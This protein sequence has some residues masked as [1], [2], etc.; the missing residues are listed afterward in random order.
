MKIKRLFAAILSAMMIISCFSFTANAQDASEGETGGTDS[1]QKVIISFDS[2][3]AASHTE[4]I[5]GKSVRISDTVSTV[6]VA[7]GEN[8]PF[9]TTNPT[10]VYN[11][12]KGWSET[13][14]GEAIADTSAIKATEA[15]TYYAVWEYTH[16]G[17]VLA[18][19]N[20]KKEYKNASSI[21]AAENCNSDGKFYDAIDDKIFKN[22]KVRT[23]GN[24]GS[25][26]M[27]NGI[28]Y[29]LG[30]TELHMVA[31]VRTNMTGYKPT[32]GVYNSYKTD[33]LSYSVSG[34]ITASEI[35]QDTD[36]DKWV[37]VYLSKTGLTDFGRGT[38]IDFDVTGNH[39]ANGVGTDYYDVVG[40]A[41][42]NTLEEAEA[43]DFDTV[44]SS[45]YQVYFNANYDNAENVTTY[46]EV[47]E[48]RYDENNNLL[49]FEGWT[50]D[51]SLAGMTVT[52]EEAASL[53][54][55]GVILSEEDLRYTAIPTADVTY[56]AVWGDTVEQE[57]AVYISADGSDENGG[58]HS[59][60][61]V[62]T[63]SKAYSLI[64]AEGSTIDTIC[65][66]GVVTDAAAKELGITGKTLTFKGYDE[67]AYLYMNA[68]DRIKICGDIS[69]ENITIESNFSTEVHF[70]TINAK[71]ITI[72]E[73]VE[74]K[75]LNSSGTSIT[76]STLVGDDYGSSQNVNYEVVVNGSDYTGT[77]IPG[78][79]YGGGTKTGNIKAVI[80]GGTISELRLTKGS[81]GSGSVDNK[82]NG[83]VEYEINGGTV[84][85]LHFGHGGN[86]NGLGYAVV[87]GGTVDMI[88]TKSVNHSWAS[89]VAN[90]IPL[91]DL[92]GVMVFEI[93]GGTVKRFATQSDG[94]DQ[95]KK[96]ISNQ[97]ALGNTVT[98]YPDTWGNI[99]RIVIFND[100][101]EA[102]KVEDTAA[103]VL[104]VT[105][106]KIK[107]VATTPTADNSYASELEGFTYTL[108][109][110]KYKIAEI[111]GTEYP[112][113][114]FTD[115]YIPVT[116]F[117]VGKVNTVKFVREEPAHIKEYRRNGYA[118][119]YVSATGAGTKD[120]SNPEN[121]LQ[122]STSFA[123]KSDA[124]LVYALIDNTYSTG[125]I[126]WAIQ[127]G[128]DIVIT[129]GDGTPFYTGGHINFTNNRNGKITF[130]NIQ[131]VYGGTYAAA[132]KHIATGIVDGE[133][134][135]TSRGS[136]MKFTETFVPVP[137]TYNGTTRTARMFI[138]P[139][140]D[141]NTNVTRTDNIKFEVY[142]GTNYQIRGGG[143]GG[144]QIAAGIDFVIGGN[145]KADGGFIASAQ[146]GGAS[147]SSIKKATFEG[148]INA[149]TA[150]AVEGATG[151]YLY[152]GS[153]YS[154]KGAASGDYYKFN[155][156]TGKPEVSQGYN[157]EGR[158]FGGTVNALIKDNANV[159]TVT[160]ALKGRIKGDFNITVTDNATVGTI[161]NTASADLSLDTI[162]PATGALNGKLT[163]PG[164]AV[165]GDIFIKIDG[166]KV[167]TI[168]GTTAGKTRNVLINLNKT[169]LPAMSGVTRA[170][171]Y[172]GDGEVS[173]NEDFTTAKLTFGENAT[174]VRITNGD[175]VKSYAVSGDEVILLEEV[176]FNAIALSEGTTTFE[177]FSEGEAI[178]QPETVTLSFYAN[179]PDADGNV[180]NT[181]AWVTKTVAWGATDDVLPVWS[182]VGR[183]SID[184][185]DTF[186][187]PDRDGYR[188]LGWATTPD[189]TSPD[190]DP[191]TFTVN[192]KEVIDGK[193]YAV[194]EQADMIAADEV[195]ITLVSDKANSPIPED[196]TG[197][198]IAFAD[199]KYSGEL[200]TVYNADGTAYTTINS[201]EA[202]PGL[203]KNTADLTGTTTTSS[204]FGASGNTNTVL[205]P[206]GTVSAWF[207]W[208][209]G[210]Y[211]GVETPCTGLVNVAYVINASPSA[212]T[213]RGFYLE[214]GDVNGTLNLTQVKDG[215]A[216]FVV[217]FTTTLEE[218]DIIKYAGPYDFNNETIKAAQLLGIYVWPVDTVYL[219][220]N[221]SD[222][223]DGYTP[224][225]AVKTLAKVNT[226]LAEN[227]NADTIVVVGTYSKK[228]ESGAATDNFAKNSC[229]NITI[230]GYDDN[231]VF[232]M[233]Y[234]SSDSH[235]RFSANVTFENIKITG[236]E[237]DGGIMS[238]GYELT[239]GEGVTVNGSQNVGFVHYT[240]PYKDG[241]I[242]NLHSGT[243]N[244]VDI[245]V[246]SGATYKGTAT[247]NVGE[248]VTTKITNG[249][250]HQGEQSVYGISNVNI[251]GGNVTSITLSATAD[252]AVT[253][254]SG[255]RYFT[256]NGGTV[257]DIT[258]TGS[259]VS[260]KY[261]PTGGTETFK[262]AS[263]R[264]GVTVFEINGG[265]V[266]TIKLGTNK[267]TGEV[268]PDNATRVVIFNNG[269]TANVT[270]TGAVV[271]NVQN[272][273]LSAVTNAYDAEGNPTYTYSSLNAE[274]GK[275]LELTGFSYTTDAANEYIYI[276]GTNYL[277]SDFANAGEEA[278]LSEEITVLIPA[279]LF[280][281]GENTA[282]FSEDPLYTVTW[283][284]GD[285]IVK[286][287]LVG[288]GA[289]VAAPEVPAKA[290][291]K[292]YYYTFK[293]WNDG[294]TD[295]DLATYTVPE[296]GATLT[297][298]FNE[299]AM[300]ASAII[301]YVGFSQVNN[302][303]GIFTT[304]VE[305]IDGVEAVKVTP[306]ETGAVAINLEGSG[307]YPENF[308][309]GTKS[310]VLDP[311]IYD[312]AVIKYYYVPGENTEARNLYMW[313]Q[314]HPWEDTTL[315]A[316]DGET[317][318]MDA[319]K[320]TY[321]VD[322][323]DRT[324]GVEP[325]IS[326]QYHIRPMNGVIASELYA[327]G[328]YVYVDSM[329]LFKS[330]PTV[331]TVSF[332]G[333]DGTVLYA[334]DA[335]NS[336]VVTYNGTAPE[337]ANHTFKGWAIEGTAEVVEEFTFAADTTL[338]P[339]FEKNAVQYYTIKFVNE[340]TT[341]LQSS[342]VAYGETPVYTGETPTKAADA[343][344][345]YTFAGWT[346]EIAAVTGEA[347]YTATYTSTINKYTITF[348]AGEGAFEDAS[349]EK[350]VEVE[351]GTTPTAPETPALSGYTFKG[352]TPEIVAVTGVATY[353]A[354]Y[355]KDEQEEVFPTTP[356]YKTYGTYN[357][358]AGTY[359]VEL[360][361]SG[362][363]ANVGSFGFSFP[364]E[365]M[366]L[367]GVTA[368]AQ[369]GIALLPEEASD[370]AQPS[371]I[372][373]KDTENGYYA[374]TWTAELA[375]GFGYIDATNEEVLIATFT[376]TMSAD[377]RS[378]FET[379]VVAAGGKFAEYAIEDADVKYYNG[380]KYL[381][382]PYAADLSTNKLPIDYVSHSD[383]VSEEE[384]TTA[385]VTLKVNFIV[386]KGTA[387]T[388]PAT[389]RVNDGAAVVI[390]SDGIVNYTIADL[391]IG[392]AY[393]L[394]VEKNGYIAGIC[395]I[396]VAAGANTLEMTLIAGDI[397][398][399]A[400]AAC[401]DGTVNLDD[402]V[403]L[404]RAFDENSSNSFKSAVDIDEDGGVSV[405]DLGF[406]KANYG[407][408]TADTVIT[409]NGE[410]ITPNVAS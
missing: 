218:G 153:L 242:I 195:A 395:E 259:S 156:T 234:G 322:K 85:R 122:M 399:A 372:F 365:Y 355:E 68:K 389:L 187:R 88:L 375:E 404:I 307:K 301:D 74:F 55:E 258:T 107:A 275:T 135:F 129:S 298:T 133:R 225:T 324:D 358:A 100:G 409:F 289:A 348:N 11:T 116:Y 272:G 380:T 182:D 220:D 141:G 35:I 4:T 132:T 202:V 337:K 194:W 52:P 393:K 255:L 28:N 214:A 190:I 254:Y 341:I 378:A 320:W 331:A 300:P 31:L 9:P 131:L 70:A 19:I 155:A 150:T 8:I 293:A 154:Q 124:K 130:D 344:Y 39:P 142:G 134:Y 327:N 71:K 243:F 209:D 317:F 296:G 199:N 83:V 92:K 16:T 284:N 340:D 274:W 115:N 89:W 264:A 288:V 230:T 159:T 323:L 377:Q 185:N 224:E 397:K 262:T 246:Q 400:N 294:T 15:K 99:H 278:S 163:L 203:A 168:E 279:N 95:V 151:L 37:K 176:D 205:F 407:K 287:E 356:T 69:F 179:I 108:T 382:A 271:I 33:G 76:T 363:T 371:P 383:T 268:D 201:G 79:G 191:A 211:I 302:V 167:N 38:H 405:T 121:A 25:C 248:G 45:D 241:G 72:G 43:Y 208:N 360:K 223:N 349:K 373:V 253:N 219:S 64:N 410:V 30:G 17:K 41:L 143:Y 384:V 59:K 354:T 401:G 376:F 77:I 44:A 78:P 166:G 10:Y 351:Y 315:K 394:Y 303:E 252:S 81:T 333:E 197:Y 22:F 62:A 162:D 94:A 270:D 269:M 367:T 27:Y 23:S 235:I 50:T 18:E 96:Y 247:I 352:W 145:T 345:T 256:I 221:G 261:T 266:G 29:S 200:A 361:L 228:N 222:E 406:I 66:V 125:T 90:P 263:V 98:A 82:F 267:Q 250:G 379:A 362:T 104:D 180:D 169:T 326:I 110:E 63:L 32:A 128:Q 120:G 346:P 119:A 170:V 40:M 309:S 321:I 213:A 113:D 112:L 14:D 328:E 126:E 318:T 149:G 36:S 277:L 387:V 5:D 215:T 217:S 374:N 398:G 273:K 237:K 282:I 26:N 308:S 366:T 144:S 392:E 238:Q 24:S 188:H 61:A 408:T 319:G 7:I 186:A 396:T 136:D 54:E 13:K 48:R 342:E 310:T 178:V 329:Q 2:R 306:T 292:D 251:N 335:L 173:F 177:F 290:P 212:T 165:D 196:A 97:A 53:A 60:D 158:T 280:N 332:K 84:S 174:H 206:D 109:D 118:V 181:T 139:G 385:D 102:I 189:A 127:S 370:A 388:S 232:D 295:I 236:S 305:T 49:I 157:A 240:N 114:T 233:K 312:Y 1:T 51:A 364:A 152:S 160:A 286:T 3:N 369:A 249:H 210:K 285:E 172:I 91:N 353:T 368:N 34:G 381:V 6:E 47:P 316:I 283:K 347:T 244:K 265:T 304:T 350:T 260:K 281:A 291:T 101:V 65:I 57:N 227:K 137:E 336:E 239:I 231:A 257:G 105:G 103:T 386:D 80:N 299:I 192:T 67:S 148:Y 171:A 314:K 146:S 245:G 56:Y 357:A 106:A 390:E 207:K 297:T 216:D 339:V 87:N 330:E 175:N 403:R 198:R 21:M 42:F 183:E 311:A 276:N 229:G 391:T 117:N 164:G 359:K 140:G 184:A 93:N 338:V 204:Y 58:R 123:G 75:G 402:F 86:F 161:S 111:N 12:F 226:I 20:A 343:Q 313:Y 46:P 73:N 147:Q 334:I 325:D 193:F 138:Q